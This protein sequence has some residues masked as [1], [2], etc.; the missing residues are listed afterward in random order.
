MNK[1]PLVSIIIP[2][3]NGSNYL[4][5]AIDSAL[6]Q[7]YNNIEVLVINDGSK[8][9]GKTEA[10][11]LEYGDRIRYFYKSNGGVSTALNLGIK[12]MIGDY[13]AWLSHDDLFTPERIS[14]DIKTFAENSGAKIT[15]CKRQIINDEGDYTIQLDYPLTKTENLMDVWEL[16]G[17]LS[18]CCLTISKECFSEVGFFD[19]KNRV[20]QD[21]EMFLRLGKTYTFYF[22]KKGLFL[23]REHAARGSHTHR[24]EH[25]ESLLLVAGTLN[26]YSVFSDFFP[27]RK[28]EHPAN[29]ICWIRLGQFFE[30]LGDNA[31]AEICFNNSIAVQIGIIGRINSLITLFFHRKYMIRQGKLFNFLRTNLKS[32]SFALSTLNGGEIV[33]LY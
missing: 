7:T 33:K 2:V 29:Y 10:V 21:V 12:E 3:Y 31:T 22:N 19:E 4:R 1:E 14:T 20:T 8:D 6:Q 18:M 9:E 24:I 30:F 28:P 11:A 32:F 17:G 5:K 27:K 25:E 16:L 15:F 23:S 26:K 13:F